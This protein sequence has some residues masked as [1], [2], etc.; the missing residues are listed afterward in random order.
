MADKDT[1]MRGGGGRGTG[2]RN[3]ERAWRPKLSREG[4]RESK[5]GLPVRTESRGGFHGIIKM[6]VDVDGRGVAWGRGAK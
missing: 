5:V 4:G 3:T 6:F 2:L 1:L